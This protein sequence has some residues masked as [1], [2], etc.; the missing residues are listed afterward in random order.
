M[1]ILL[2]G[3]YKL[4]L[5]NTYGYKIEMN[6]RTLAGEGHSVGF[7]K[8]YTLEWLSHKITFIEK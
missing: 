7:L 6:F 4:L 3:T 8:I 5:H 2:M 1:V